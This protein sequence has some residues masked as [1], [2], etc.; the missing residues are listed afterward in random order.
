MK[1]LIITKTKTLKNLRIDRGLTQEQLA[2]SIGKQR[3]YI[4][5]LENGKRN[6]CRIE[7]ATLVKIATI[8]GTTAEFI[9]GAEN[10]P[11]QS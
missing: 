2:E 8:L 3:S 9:L 4:A 7:A 5:D 1:G 6:V 11:P 10:K